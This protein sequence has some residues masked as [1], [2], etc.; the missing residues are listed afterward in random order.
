MPNLPFR[1]LAGHLIRNTLG[2]SLCCMV[3]VFVVQAAIMLQ[4]HRAEFGNLA[5][6]VAKTSVP[7]L[8]FS[9][10]DIEPRAVQKQVELIAQRPQIGYVLLQA[11]TG[12]TFEAGDARLRGQPGSLRVPIPAPQGRSVVGELQLW[13]NPHFVVNEMLRTAW[14]V[15]A[16]YGIF[17][18]LICGLIATMLRRELQMPLQR[19]AEFARE[20]TPQTLT[21]PLALDRPRRASLDE[22]DQVADGFS[23]LQNGLRQHIANL[24][25]MVAERTQ[26]LEALVEANHQLSITDPLTGCFNRRTLEP[27]L[28]DEIE[29]AHRYQRPFSVI[30]LDLDHFKKINDQYGHPAGDAV[31]RA[32]AEHLRNA[33]RFRLDWTVRM[34]GEEFLVV[35]PETVLAT[36][37][38]NAERLRQLLQAEPVWFEG[39]RIGLTASFGVAQWQPE[40]SA[41]DLVQQAD[42]LLYQAKAAGRNRVF[43]EA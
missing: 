21:Q 16:G 13:G 28:Q 27:R 22:I 12:Q 2:L 31:L 6:E 25:Q 32:T 11:G 41:S 23:K 42:A 29:R 15:L 35:L 20:L 39:Q 10:W 38:Q 1:S 9:L 18:L 24:D 7:L 26:Q 37:R 4:H 36:A 19:L 43:P 30:C 17:T 8:S 33:T 40:Q 34:G 3:A 5:D 14:T